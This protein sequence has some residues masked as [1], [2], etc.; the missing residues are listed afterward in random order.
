MVL[1]IVINC[2]K[3]RPIISHLQYLVMPSK[4]SK[5][6]YLFFALVLSFELFA[7]EAYHLDTH[8]VFAHS[9]SMGHL[10]QEPVRVE[11][12]GQHE[13]ENNHAVDL[14]DALKYSAGVQM[15]Q[16]KGKSGEGVWLQ[17]Y[18]SDRVAVLVDGLPVA[19]GTGSS[20]DI[21]QIAIGDVERIEVSKGAMSAI[22]G[23]SAMGG[24][25][26]VITKMPKQGQA[27]SLNYSGG[28][29]GSQ[30]ESYDRI[31]MGKQHVQG[32]Y[33]IGHSFG[34]QQIVIDSQ[35]SNGYRLDGSSKTQGWAGDKLNVSGKSVFKL[36]DD[37]TLTLA[38]RV[39][40]E[41]IQTLD[42]N[43]VPAIGFVPKAKVDL[44][45][46]FFISA[47]LEKNTANNGQLKLSYSVED[48]SNEARQDTLQTD[49]IEQTRFT[50]IQHQGF[51]AQ[52]QISPNYLNKYVV[53]LELLSDSMNVNKRKE[54]SNGN[55]TTAINTTEVNDKSVENINGYFQFSQQLGSSLEGLLSARVNNNPK[56]GTEISP[57]LN[58]QYFLQ[59]LLTGNSSI[60]FG[61]G[62]GYRTPN[63]KELYYF[64]D[65]SH[66]SYIIVG[67]ENLKPESSKNLQA[68]FE[69]QPNKRVSFDTTLYYN[70]IRNLIT[71]DNEIPELTQEFSDTFGT[72]EIP[73]VNGYQY[74][75][76]ENAITSGLE[77][78]FSYS[79]NDFVQTR[80]AY[81]YLYSEDES[82]GKSLT[83]RPEHDAKLSL[84]IGLTERLFTSVK[85][86]YNSEQF[87][88]PE[89]KQR[90]PS[91][92]Q[93]D[94]KLNY[95]LS[96]NLKLYGG[97]NN[98]TQVHKT[99]FDQPDLRPSEGRYVYLGIKLDNL[100]Q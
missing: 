6:T 100:I 87:S 64:F 19:A 31:P 67:N 40:Q 51:I 45:D 69:W 79:F 72:A 10:S 61:Y 70:Q 81:A 29:W 90:T 30:D 23:T 5:L 80:L 46:K 39:Y 27:A 56:Y 60:R 93:V 88:D 68:S 49:R 55:Q 95:N 59:D 9:Q 36:G 96:S 48:F 1:R 53:G 83:Q 15:R 2:N 54:E 99:N 75:N 85:Y 44:T 18:S 37:Q 73:T 13:L 3:V 98:L 34:Y 66:I 92:S 38:P 63:I 94:L 97:V 52:Y 89:N 7:E 24:V 22:Y 86:I 11:L 43:L 82:T 16:L 74:R 57:M 47:L 62:H 71:D 78:N 35:I 4:S 17:G 8:S 26:N 14:K 41:D 91:F 12:I 32:Q 50:D 84:D 21:S 76:V 28:S 65:H 42:D 58:F 33:S 77:F 20:V 25:V